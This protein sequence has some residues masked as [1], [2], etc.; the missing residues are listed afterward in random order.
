MPA[1]LGLGLAALGRPAYVNVGHGDDV[2][3]GPDVSALETQAHTVLD[4]AWA[5]GIRHIDAA[6]SYGLAERFLGSWL[7]LHPL[8]RN[9]LTIGSKWGYTYV[10]DWQVDVDVHEVKDHSLATFERQW[11]ESLA[12]LGTT[13]DLYLVHSL[14]ADS[15]AL[16][17]VRLLAGL[18]EIGESGVRV[19]LSTS[20]ATQAEV[21][22]RA[23]AMV[24]S[25][26]SAVQSTWNL[27][28]PS[29]G[30]ALAE[31][32]ARGWHVAIKESVANGLLTDRSSGLPDVLQQIAAARGTTV[33]AVAIA[34][35]RTA[36][37]ASVVLLG[38][39]TVEQLRSNVQ[40][41]DLSLD[42]DELE[43]LAGLAEEPSAYWSRRSQL[44]WT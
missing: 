34:A 10:A 7:A 18:R 15:P 31:A 23:L 22:R 42:T 26:F 36:V 44:S 8:R 20:G 11:P 2:G 25:P 28:E 13:P 12:A 41:L 39:S 3:H 6:R 17:D 24:D 16:D 43:I 32:A 30:D 27:L 38:A 19:G 29:V 5:L 14:T 33:D 9:V 37:P 35:A 4:E 21:L 40:A 1:A